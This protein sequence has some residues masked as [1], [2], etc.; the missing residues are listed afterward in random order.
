MMNIRADLTFIVMGRKVIAPGIARG[1]PGNREIG[2]TLMPGRRNGHA[3]PEQK[4]VNRKQNDEDV[5]FWTPSVRLH[6]KP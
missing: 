6:K 5:L 1:F 3:G 4:N 2:P